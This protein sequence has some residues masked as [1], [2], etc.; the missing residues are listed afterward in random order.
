[1]S[2]GH[3]RTFRQLSEQ[4]LNESHSQTRDKLTLFRSGDGDIDSMREN[5]PLELEDVYFGF[6]REREDEKNY[7]ALIAYIPEGVSGVKRGTG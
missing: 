1:M 7:Y 6:C 5:I 4:C 3:V 2:Y